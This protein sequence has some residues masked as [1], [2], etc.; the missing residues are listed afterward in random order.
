MSCRKTATPGAEV[1]AVIQGWLPV[2]VRGADPA[3]LAEVLPVARSAVAAAAPQHRD[4]AERMLRALV[5]L[6]LW[7]RRSLGTVDVAAVLVPDVVEHWSMVVN[8]QLKNRAWRLDARGILTRIG[9]AAN[10]RGWPKARKQLG[11]TTVAPPYDAHGEVSWRVA[12]GRACKP[13]CADEAFVV[14]AAP[15][16]GM[17]G[18]EIAAAEPSDIVDLGNGRLAVRVKGRNARLVPI[19]RH[20]TQLARQAVAAAGGKRFV[21][22]RDRNAVHRVAEDLAAVGGKGLSLRRARSTFLAAHLKAGTPLA[23]LRVLA[24]PVSMRTLDDLLTDAARDV[25]ADTAVQQGLE[26]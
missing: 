15:G 12:G 23:A 1:A 26:A 11:S 9:R 22:S 4:D 5:P 17:S 24:G 21:R 18:P 14:V 25:D 8:D 16:V 19:R 7:A 2:A 20:Y 3:A 6:L 10:P 13:A